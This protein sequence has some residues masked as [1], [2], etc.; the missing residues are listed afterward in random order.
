MIVNVNKQLLYVLMKINNYCVNE[1]ITMS[2]TV[3]F[4]LNKIET[5]NVS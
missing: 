2:I 4:D 1:T 3:R 5:Y